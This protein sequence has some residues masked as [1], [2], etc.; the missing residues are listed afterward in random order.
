MEDLKDLILTAL[1]TLVGFLA[2]LLTLNIVYY[3]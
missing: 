2:I 1:F 3:V